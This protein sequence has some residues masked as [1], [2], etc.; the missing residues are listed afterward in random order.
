MQSTRSRFIGVALLVCLFATGMATF[1]NY[2]KYKSTL[3]QLVQTRLLVIGY[4][5]E[6]S[7]QSSLGLGLAFDDLTTLPSLMA[8]EKQSDRLISGI[9]VF[10][11]GGK[12]LY[13]TDPARVGKPV[14]PSWLGATSNAKGRD[15]STAEPTELVAGIALKNNFDLTVGYLAMRYTRD[16][17]DQ[18]VG[19]MAKHLLLIGAVAFAF[20]LSIAA[21]ILSYLLRRYERDMRA[22]EERIAGSGD[23]AAVPEAF[24]P[25]VEELRD[26]IAEADAGLARVRASIAGIR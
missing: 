2:Y 18:N 15:W 22:I 20:S 9:D 5:I 19:A 23:G 17:V 26:A 3:G 4:G 10:E 24:A 6:N 14:A 1:L 13:S 7:V 25:A 12:V 16:Y 8:R 11:T 21:L